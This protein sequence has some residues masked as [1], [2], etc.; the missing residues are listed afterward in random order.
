VDDHPCL[1]TEAIFI[2]EL[3]SLRFGSTGLL[4]HID[5]AASQIQAVIDV[6]GEGNASLPD[7]LCTMGSVLMRRFKRTGCLSDRDESIR[8]HRRAVELTGPGH[9]S[10]PSSLHKL[11][12]SLHCSS[13]HTGN[14]PELEEGILLLH[15]LIELT[16]K[17]HES[18]PGYLCD[19]E[20]MLESRFLS[21]N[22]APNT[23][24]QVSVLRGAVEACQGGDTTILCNCLSDLAS[25]LASLWR[26]TGDL[27]HLQEAIM[28]GRKI[29][30]LT[31]DGHLLLPSYLHTLA[32]HLRMRWQA[33][34]QLSDL[35]ESISIF[36]RVVELCPRGDS[37]VSH[38]H[39]ELGH[40][41]EMR[42][43]VTHNTEDITKAISNL[44]RSIQLIPPGHASLPEHYLHLATSRHERFKETASLVRNASQRGANLSLPAHVLAQYEEDVKGWTTALKLAA[45]FPVGDP[46]YRMW[47]A[48]KWAYFTMLWFPESPDI[49]VALD[50]ALGLLSLT[51]GFGQT[52]RTRHIHL[53][54][55]AAVIGTTATAAFMACWLNRPDKALEWLEQGRCLV[56]NQINYLRTPLDNLRIHSPRL[57]ETLTDVSKRLEIAGSSLF[58][59]PS[60]MDMPL[61]QRI[62]LQEEATAHLGLAQQWEELLHQV[63]A[64]P[65]FESFLQPEKCSSLLKNLPEFGVIIVVNVHEVQC[66]AIALL[67]GLDDPLHI[68]LP[69]FS[70]EKAKQHRRVLGQQLRSRELRLRKEDLGGD[71]EYSV[72]AVGG[73]RQP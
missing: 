49:L 10:S 50:T 57:A 63:R 28:T 52:I 70:E 66:D 60:D 19:L 71:E 17:G 35:D 31:S 20:S 37:E 64:I 55:Q 58:R 14:L 18:L 44:E 16:P 72:R 40:S 48:L 22:D 68:P 23:S 21:T 33:T 69:N 54:S 13:T 45:T 73:Y 12:L 62:V 30:T 56:W 67:D 3:M 32:S 9:P 47:G 5:E 25:S 2:A 46:K 39:T 34:G 26:S 8:A 42:Y 43:E 15:R 4:V 7:L 41:L 6:T 1:A 24:E 59:E 36:E 65:G 11:A 61:R 51:V 27:M 38:C 53:Q 29:L